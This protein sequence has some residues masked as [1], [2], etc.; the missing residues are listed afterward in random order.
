[1]A[2]A[3]FPVCGGWA[4]APVDVLLDVMEELEARPEEAVLRYLIA[5]QLVR[6]KVLRI[7]E[8][9]AEPS[10]AR[11]DHEVLTLACRKRRS[12]YRVAVVPAEEAVAEGVE[13]RLQALLWSGGEA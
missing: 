12:E 11:D 5:L 4:D 8:R 3:L 13:Q 7:V 1:V 2:V 9:A 6:R 10:T